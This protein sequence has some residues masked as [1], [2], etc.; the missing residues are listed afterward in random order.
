[1]PKI[2]DR[3]QGRATN[4]RPLPGLKEIGI[5]RRRSPSHVDVHPLDLAI[6]LERRLVG[7]LNAVTADRTRRHRHHAS[8]GHGPAR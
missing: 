1:M 4:G 3:E 5:Q 6:E 2:A 8:D 7:L